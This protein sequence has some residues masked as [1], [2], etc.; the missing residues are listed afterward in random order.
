MAEALSRETDRLYTVP[1]KDFV[2]ARDALAAE[3][4]KTG[5]TAEAAEVA[6]LRK[7]TP[8]VW[9]INQV[10]QADPAAVTR[11]IDTVD[12]LKRAHFGEP[13]P[14]AQATEDQ[15]AALEG[16]LKRAKALL[17]KVGLPASAATT[18]RISA[19]LLG[20]A[21]DPPARSFLRHGRLT[22]ERQAPGFEAL[23]GTAEPGGARRAEPAP[24]PTRSSARGMPQERA[25]TVN[26][27]R[28]ALQA[29]ESE[30][31]AAKSRAEEAERAAA[32]QR[33]AAEEAARDA[34]SLRQRLRK[35]EQ[36]AQAARRA[37]EDAAGAAW[38]ARRDAEGVESRREAAERAL[39]AATKRQ[40]RR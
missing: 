29:A 14:L 35:A 10:A 17:A 6:K 7:P 40:Q 39:Q 26:R 33:Q 22:H 23:A 18:G 9:A 21:A 30:A 28:E 5:R 20:A 19:T 8:A 11:F 12:R 32:Q 13:G 3:L 2:K 24:K 31:R 16:L 27:A 1:P 15:R 38:R 37:A 4:R 36:R 34:E 25:D